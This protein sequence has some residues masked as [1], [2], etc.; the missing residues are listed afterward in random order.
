[1]RD[2][3]LASGRGSASMK[4]S[5][6]F[7]ILPDPPRRR[8]H[9]T[10]EVIQ[11]MPVYY[12]Y[13]P[14]SAPGWFRSV[15]KL[16]IPHPAWDRQVCFDLDQTEVH[17]QGRSVEPRVLSASCACHYDPNSSDLVSEIGRAHV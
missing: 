2:T 12:H 17:V 6:K 13:A 9:L 8:R 10:V 4:K 3:A 16:G 11:R 5:G 14:A 1:M 15:P 7:T